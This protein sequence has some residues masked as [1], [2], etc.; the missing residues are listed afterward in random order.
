MIAIPMLLLLVTIM[1]FIVAIMNDD[2][3][4]IGTIAILSA[5]LTVLSLSFPWKAYS[6]EQRWEM[7]NTPSQYTIATGCMIKIGNKWIPESNY[8]EFEE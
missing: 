1:L 7:S 8:R 2:N 4:F 3:G 5:T 6:C